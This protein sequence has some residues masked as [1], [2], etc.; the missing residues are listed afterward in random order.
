MK[1][2]LQESYTLEELCEIVADLRSPEGCPWDRVQ[3]YDSIKTCL[4]DE[5]QEVLDAV[6][7]RDIENLKEELG[8][9]LLQVIFYAQLAREDGLFTLEDVMNGLGRKLVRRHPHVF[10]DAKA[11][12]PE[13]ALALWRSVKKKERE[14]GYR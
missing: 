8:D 12:T 7:H 3:D 6:D 4:R 1:R 2:E 11:E 13:E 9:L 14:E 5:T 10:G